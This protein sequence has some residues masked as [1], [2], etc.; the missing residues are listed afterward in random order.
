MQQR[1]SGK[2]ALV[3]GGTSGIGA[4]TAGR[5]TREGAKVVFTGSNGEAAAAVERE[6]GAIFRAHRVEDAAAWDALM[7]E[8][9]AEFGRL[10]IAFANA[11]TE[12]G[13]ASVE[14]IDIDAWNHIV[15][16]NQT[17]VMLT[18]QHAIRAMAKN[19]QGP[20]GSI[21]VNSSM[22]AHRAMGNY[23]AYSVTKA[24]VVALVKSAAIHC[25]GKGYRVRVNAILPGV[26][27]TDMIRGVI[28][29][30]PDPAAARA[31]FEGMAPMKRMA[32][33]DEVAAL[34]AFL[35][36]DEAGFISGADYVIDGATTAGMMG[37]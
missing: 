6:T 7:A 15:G 28:D 4:A 17:G 31:A 33:L 9:E 34:V 29:R 23:A 16:V 11:G 20:T 18:V 27:E 35:A 36:S 13:D 24:A 5:L 21:I 30:S 19:P 2:V 22:N 14:D 10:D 8:I 26:V 32:Q 3:T 25:A 1:L 12:A 37:V